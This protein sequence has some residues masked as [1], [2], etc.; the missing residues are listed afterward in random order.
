MLKNIGLEKGWSKSVARKHNPIIFLKSQ[1]KTCAHISFLFP[2]RSASQKELSI[3][4]WFK[5]IGEIFSI[6][7]TKVHKGQTMLK[8]TK[9][10]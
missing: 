2:L 5:V 3:P 1:I 8:N 9:G 6:E 10:I 7:I 4:A